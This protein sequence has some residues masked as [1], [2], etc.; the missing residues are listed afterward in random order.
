MQH[1]H[2][3]QSIGAESREI[4]SR[5]HLRFSRHEEKA[6]DDINAD[7]TVPLSARG[8][9]H[10]K[11]SATLE[12]ASQAIAYGSPRTRALE[13]AAFELLGK[14]DG[15][16]GTESLGELETKV[17]EALGSDYPQ[18]ILELEDLDF[19]LDTESTYGK[20]LLGRYLNNKDYVRALL[21]ESDAKRDALITAGDESA[22]NVETA[23]VYARRLAKIILKYIDAG[24]RWNELVNDPEK[25]YDDT[26]TRYFVSHGGIN[27][28]FLGKVI[29]RIGGKGELEKFISAVPNGFDFHEGFDLDIETSTDDSSRIVVSYIKPASSEREGYTFTGE[30]SE[31]LLHELARDAAETS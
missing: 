30:V 28:S 7:A 17:S 23:G 26:L 2:P 25:G 3:E 12:D 8:K 21:L 22:Q 18:K 16:M 27:E 11:E 4:P 29:E 20:W 1:N 19:H 24:G 9:M 31:A 15:V 14:Q 10:A 6:N 5:I 13:T